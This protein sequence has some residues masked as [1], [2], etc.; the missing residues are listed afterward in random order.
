MFILSRFTFIAVTCPPYPLDTVEVTYSRPPV[1]D[2]GRYTVGTRVYYASCGPDYRKYIFH[3]FNAERLDSGVMLNAKQ[4][5]V[6]VTKLVRSLS[7]RVS[8]WTGSLVQRGGLCVETWQRPLP[9][10]KNDRRMPLKISSSLMVGNNG[11][12]TFMTCIGLGF[13]YLMENRQL[14]TIYHM[15]CPLPLSITITDNNCLDFT[16]LLLILTLGHCCRILRTFA[17]DEW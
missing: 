7:R 12:Q 15:C 14:D 17:S 2:S 9:G 10:E 13:L 16:N 4:L 6:K 11:W 3:E 5:H 1:N 8:V